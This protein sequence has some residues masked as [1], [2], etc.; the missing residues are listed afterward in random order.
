MSLDVKASTQVHSQS[1]HW[2]VAPFTN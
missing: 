1:Q 2:S